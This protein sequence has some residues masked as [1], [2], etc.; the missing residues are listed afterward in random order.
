M[1]LNTFTRSVAALLLDT[2]LKGTVLLLLACMAVWRCRR[3]S[4]ALRHSIWRITMVGLLLLPIASL[5]LPEWQIPILPGNPIAAQEADVEP[6]TTVAN[7]AIEEAARVEFPP[8]DAGAF[9]ATPAPLTALSSA[10]IEPTSSRRTATDWTALV[11]GAGW[12]LGVAVCGFLLLAGFGKTVKLRRTSL[13]ITDGDWLRRLVEL[14]QR[15]K[16]NRTVELREHSKS[17]VP[18][19]CGILRPVVL[20]P[21]LAR[22]WSEPML[23]AVLLHELAHVQRGD[24]ACQMLGRLACAVYWFHPLSWYALRRLRQEREHACDDAVVHAGEKASA[25]A[26]QLL[27]VARL[28]CAPS[29]LSLGVAMAE[30]SSLEN[31]VKS[32][33]DSTRGHGPVS[34]RIILLSLFL[35]MV[36]VCSLAPIHPIASSAGPIVAT[37]EESEETEKS[38]TVPDTSPVTVVQLEIDK[39]PASAIAGQITG[40]IIDDKKIG[41][42]G[43]EVAL[44][45]YD[46]AN[47]GLA[48]QGRVIATTVADPLG[49]YS[50]KL[51]A[52]ES[53]QRK[54]GAVWAK[55]KGHV[56]ARSNWSTVIAAL[57]ERKAELKLAETAGIRVRV[58]DAAGKPLSGAKLSPI[59]VGVP[60]GVG[61]PL[62]KEWEEQSTA[63]TDADGNALMPHIDPESLKGLDLIPPGDMGVLRYGLN[64]FLNV[65]PTSG[66]FEFQLPET[67]SI[68]GQLVVA[69]GSALPE[70]LMLTLKSFSRPFSNSMGIV[71][72][73]VASD[74]KFHV[75][76]I[77]VGRLFVPAFLPENQPLRADVPAQIDVEANKELKIQIP[78][79]PGVKIHGRVQKSDTQEGV[80]EFPVVVLYGQTISNRSADFEWL[81]FELETDANG[82]FA[83]FVPPGP[84]DVQT[85]L[86][87]EGYSSAHSWLPQ[88][89]RGNFGGMRFVV[90]AGETYDLGIYNL[91]RNV[92]IK[93][94]VVDMQNQ[95]LVDWSVYGFPNIPEFRQDATMN[96]M[97]GVHTDKEGNFNGSYPQMYPPAYW[98]VSHRVW[99]T[100]YEFDDLN[101]AALVISREPLILQVDTSKEVDHNDDIPIDPAA[102]VSPVTIPLPSKSQE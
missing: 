48:K 99:K 66:Q 92:G 87:I 74:G 96:S 35:A 30:G 31:R 3:S 54:F 78:I 42:A 7:I 56:A 5:A 93:G 82:Q 52:E 27:H 62:P 9:S 85:T 72:V 71:T 15:L 81:K 55:A 36:M 95:P 40:Q 23:R 84:I 32:L 12:L 18:L 73:P 69:T 51:P 19:T 77:A 86:R 16:L 50:L 4:A 17:I 11:V 88:D 47:G 94:N 41:I 1:D 20:L 38:A 49:N 64:Y 90:P 91:S 43:A 57:P 2:S 28:C 53:D 6:P 102:P 76:K 59:S 44:V 58:V 26:E 14:Q 61:Y 70:N 75:D 45:A 60:R 33:F 34:R 37:I 24:V 8:S 10:A 63:I 79:E 80:P 83:C 25:Y 39:N 89:Q 22:D 97:G 65:R 68:T 100:K 46:V 98:K 21:K 101:Y 29:G 67:G 13:A